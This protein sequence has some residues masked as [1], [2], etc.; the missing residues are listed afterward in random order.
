M[1]AIA[2]QRRVSKTG[3]LK[4]RTHYKL[5]VPGMVVCSNCGELKLSHR[6]CP[7]CGFY[8]GKQVKEIKQKE[9]KDNE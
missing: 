9:N 5:E 6:V 1:G 4:R 8:N 2:Q 7:E 3:K